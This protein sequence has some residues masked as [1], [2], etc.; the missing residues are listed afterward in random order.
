M[1][2]DAA[3]RDEPDARRP[4]ARQADARQAGASQAGAVGAGPIG[5][6]PRVYVL[7]AVGLVV[8]ALAAVI[9]AANTNPSRLQPKVDTDNLP[10]GPVAPTINGTGW[11][12]SPPLTPAGL[13]GKVVLYDFWTYSCINCVDTVPY[14]RSWFDRYRRDGLVVVGIHTPE[15]DFEHN[16]ANVLRAIKNLGVTWPVAFD[17]KMT[18]WDAFRNNSWPADY[19]ADR[20]GHIRYVSLGE[21]NYGQTENVIRT[22]LGVA[23]GSPR[24]VSPTGGVNTSQ[25]TA[26]ITPETYLG[27]AHG[28]DAQPGPATYPEP[29]SVPVDTDKLVGQWTG[30]AQY[31]QAGAAGSAIVVHYQAQEVNLV[32]APPPTGPVEVVVEL[33]GKPL[34]PDD[35]TSQTVVETDGQTSVLVASA[36]MYRL[37]SGPTVEGHT[38]RITVGA[39]GLLAYDFT[40]EP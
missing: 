8:V 4:D 1:P 27:L 30:T 5:A 28:D 9:Y 23:S 35:R 12:N 31:V 18:V 13:A 29:T 22:L 34:P 37:V 24:A 14:V 36:D 10:V 26:D 19:L 21:G 20:T 25:P 3:G 7:V 17:D 38:L 16:H 11:A 39:P 40:F 33:D 2:P 32:M 6:R 15:F